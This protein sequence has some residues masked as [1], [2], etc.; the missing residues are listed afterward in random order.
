M[1]TSTR[2]AKLPEKSGFGK[3]QASREAFHSQQSISESKSVAD[4]KTALM[5]NT[6]QPALLG[7]SRIGGFC[8]FC[9]WYSQANFLLLVLL[10]L[11]S[12]AIVLHIGLALQLQSII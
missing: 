8:Q 5:N 9:Y 4:S 12:S 3:L 6:A 11:Y 10:W 7:F 2:A 1:G